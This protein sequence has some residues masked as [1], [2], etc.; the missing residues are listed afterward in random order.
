MKPVVVVSAVNVVELGPLSI[1]K[2][3]LNVLSACYSREYDL[4]AVVHRRNLFDIPGIRF[5]EYPSI[6]SSWLKRL[7][8]EYFD[9]R[10]LSRELSAYLWLSMHDMSPRVSADIQ[11]VYCQNAT[12]SFRFRLR[13][14]W[15]EWKVALFTLFYGYLFGINIKANRWVI[16]QQSWIRGEFR[17]RYG[18]DHIVVA[19]PE[20]ATPARLA[21]MS[22]SEKD[23]GRHYRFFYPCFP[24]SFKNVETL[25]EAAEMLER[26]GRLKFEVWLTF[27]GTENR[28]AAGLVRRFRG[29]QC[30]KFLGRLRRDQVFDRYAEVDCLVF[31][32]H[33]ESW[34]L[35]ISEF[36]QFEK[37]ML[38]AD[39]PYAHETVGNYS[40]VAF[41]APRDARQLVQQMKTA[42]EGEALF[43]CAVAPHIEQ[44]Y[45]KSWEELF[46]LLLARVSAE[47]AH[48]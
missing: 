46:E 9:L 28:Y 32:S 29:L 27:D 14:L 11:A 2:D 6:K 1:L 8:F 40:Q 24:R 23:D 20:T 21:G 3:A 25:L 12:P 42:I 5:L 16:V 48:R 41:F 44:P 10:K 45:C 36:R 33:L 26:D 47:G 38:L 19:R 18:V 31:A 17:R 7:K 37:P 30:A 4:V 39:L 22:E 43:G 15:V 13:D 35:P 34:G